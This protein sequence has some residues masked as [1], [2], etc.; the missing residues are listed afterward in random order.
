MAKY[1]IHTASIESVFLRAACTAE[2]QSKVGFSVV[3]NLF[4]S[5]PTASENVKPDYIRSHNRGRDRK[6]WDPRAPII[7][8]NFSIFRANCAILMSYIRADLRTCR[9]LGAII[10][11]GDR[12]SWDPRAPII[13][14]NFSIFRAN[15]A[16]LMSYIRADLRTC[17][18]L[19]S[20]GCCHVA[21]SNGESGE[22][23]FQIFHSDFRE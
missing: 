19:Y 22:I 13:W 8:E 4:Q 11:D 18:G 21:W 20:R 3:F 23:L 2:S 10:G 14:E 16:I 15:C 12:K 6:S 1:K 7:W 9:I 17:R 5:S